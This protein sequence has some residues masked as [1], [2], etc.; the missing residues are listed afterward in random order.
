MTHVGNASNSIPAS[1]GVRGAAESSAATFGLGAET[2]FWPIIGVGPAEG[3]VEGA[4]E[5][6]AEGDTD[7]ATE[8]IAEGIAEG[9]AA[10]LSAATGGLDAGTMFWPITSVGAAE[11]LT[12]GNTDGY[13][14]GIAEG[15]CKTFAFITRVAPPAI[16][17]LPAWL[18]F[19]TAIPPPEMTAFLP[20]SI[21]GSASAATFGLGAGTMISPIPSVSAAEGVT[22]GYIEGIAK[23]VRKTF[24]L[25]TRVAPPAMTAFPA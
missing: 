24:A 16:I 8:G 25:I 4:T 9:L 7:G 23:G 1:P 21:S 10:G 22:D 3:P 15:V 19:S 14:E 6:S 20:A 17:A 12:E 13:M 2:M 5:G 11:G 18:E